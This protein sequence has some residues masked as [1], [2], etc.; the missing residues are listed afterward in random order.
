MD[1][2]SFSDCIL[3]YEDDIWILTKNKNIYKYQSEDNL[4]FLMLCLPLLENTSTTIIE[5][6]NNRF[7]E[8]K[9]NQTFRTSFPLIKLLKLGLESH[10]LHWATHSL[11]WIES[12]GIANEFKIELANLLD[13][14]L[15]KK[16]KNNK[17]KIQKWL[18]DCN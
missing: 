1:I 10:S 12:L 17:D 11:R 16:Q 13:T 2:L 15:L 4:Y 18:R 3:S 14:S 9:I 7:L 8:L 5:S 6:V